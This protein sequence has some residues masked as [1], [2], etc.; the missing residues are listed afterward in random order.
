[1][2]SNRYTKEEIIEAVKTSKSYSEVCRK[3]GLSPRGGNPS[4]IKRK[5]E[6]YGLDISHF[7]FGA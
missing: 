1:M 7:T 6:E 2:A 3:L 4:T 5:I